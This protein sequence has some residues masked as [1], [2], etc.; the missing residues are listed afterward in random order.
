MKSVHSDPDTVGFKFG[1]PEVGN[2]SYTSDTQYFDE[3]GDYYEGARLVILC[4][5]RSRGSQ[6]KGH[7]LT[8][9]LMKKVNG[10]K[11]ETVII[12]HFG[13]K[14]IFGNPAEEAKFI[15]KQTGVP[16]VAALDGMWV[17]VGREIHFVTKRRR[18]RV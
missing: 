14:M 16:T 11:P 9:N 2:V 17:D 18:Q 3:I 10:V 1:F 8:S 12:T 13:M 4:V 5:M 15:E 7:M 6:W